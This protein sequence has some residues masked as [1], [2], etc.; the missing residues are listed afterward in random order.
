M[1]Q[2][3][4]EGRRCSVLLLGI[5]LLLGSILYAPVSSAAPVASVLLSGR[6]TSQDATPIPA[7]TL[8][9]QEGESTFATSTDSA[10]QFTISVPTGTYDVKLIPPSGY[11]ETLI[12]G[13]V[14][15]QDTTLN[16][17]LV[18]AGQRRVSGVVRGAG[19]APRP[20]VTVE[21]R[22]GA[23]RSVAT[24]KADGSY[25]LGVPQGSYTLGIALASPEAYLQGGPV[26]VL[27]DLP[28][29][30]AVPELVP[31][32][33]RVT[34]KAGAPVA[35]GEVRFP[36]CDGPTTSFEAA[37]GVRVSGYA[38]LTSTSTSTGPDGTVTVF[39]LPNLVYP[40]WQSTGAVT[41]SDRLLQVPFPMP[42]VGTDPVVIVVMM[43]E[44]DVTAPRVTGVLERAPNHN[45]WVN[46]P[47][48]ISWSVTDPEPSSG[49]RS[50]PEDVVAA[51]EGRAVEYTSSPA[52]DIA[53]NCATGSVRVSLDAA[54][55]TI[56]A[57]V[58]SRNPA[59]TGETTALTVSASDAL[60]GV[61]GGE[62][63]LD[64]DPGVGAG[65]AMTYVSG[66][67]QG[68]LPPLSPGTYRVGVR[69]V[70]AADNWSTPQLATLVVY[71]PDGGFATGVGLI[72]PGGPTSDPGDALPGL[73]SISKASF[74][75]VV[76]YQAGNSTPTGNLR[77]MYVAGSFQLSSSGFDWLVV[78][79]SWARFS[80]RATVR[81]LPGTFVFRVDA[82]D[83]SS[84]DRADRLILRAWRDGVDVER[85]EPLFK[86]S[87]DVASG[88]IMIH[89]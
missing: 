42:N 13:Y 58:F 70:D 6:V 22:Q 44:P 26:N 41:S 43:R 59:R 10:G 64:D 84:S 21:L 57:P 63:Y 60:A 5:A 34:D 16:L 89:R 4:S 30:L 77:F 67:L 29:D 9:L 81:G 15:S 23:V 71:N 40:S 18:P 75:F 87:G 49:I 83:G 25:A 11:A 78:N 65:T 61:V 32:T 28:L 39:G 38:R 62:W 56:A 79:Q 53:G 20:G 46:S 3:H 50:R 69:A 8:V 31:V 73:D 51:T 35:G 24:T 88:Q 12:T 36:C 17:V 19:G 45:G 72:T 2:R 66:N 74:A 27:A 85:S 52:C 37:P 76:S 33:V 1:R 80:G 48:A 14:L 86:A 54:P 68:T 7:V 55:P 82:Y 47:V